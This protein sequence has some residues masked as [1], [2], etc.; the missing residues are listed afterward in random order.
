MNTI[1]AKCVILLVLIILPFSVSGQ[2]TRE[3]G[4]GY[5][6]LSSWYL[7]SD[8]HYNDQGTIDPNATRGI[9]TTS[10]YAEYGITKTWNLVAYLPF[11]SRTYQN[12]VISLTTGNI[13][14][15]GEAINA[16]GDIELG[17]VYGIIDAER[18]SLSG[19]LK[20][21]IPSGENNGGSDGSYQTG[22]GEFNQ[23]VLIN[24]G[25]PL[26]VGLVSGYAKGYLGFN[27]RTNNFS[28]EWHVGMEL[29]ANLWND[30]LLLIGKLQVI[31]SF[32]NGS[33]NA[34]NSQGSIFANNVE[35]VNLGGEV[36]FYISKKWGL[37]LTYTNPISGRIIF[38]SPSYA[39]GI[40]LE[41]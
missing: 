12:D 18:F 4:K 25:I 24:G 1:D 3:K 39:G 20:L 37:S 30:R 16:V 31:E 23:L 14:A 11:F 36:A 13:I 5:Y 32:K 22:D 28:D 17:V 33:L 7:E 40:F 26:T 10:L 15:E 38:V 34:E 8:Q 19:T 9:F 29:G 21:G 35:Y 41:I 27:N 6:K 2:W